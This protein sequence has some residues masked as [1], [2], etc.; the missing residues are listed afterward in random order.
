VD[1]TDAT[2]ERVAAGTNSERELADW[3]RSPRA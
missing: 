1:E 2:N 3:L